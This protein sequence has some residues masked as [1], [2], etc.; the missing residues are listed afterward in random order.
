V[1]G[2]IVTVLASLGGALGWWVGNLE[3]VMTGFFLSVVGTAVGVYLARRLI[4]E[5]LP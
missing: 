2:L 5:Y 1:K 3:G 4:V